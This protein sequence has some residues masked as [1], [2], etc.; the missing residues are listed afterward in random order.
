MSQQ[1]LMQL[2]GGV[3]Q[4]G[5]LSSLLGSMNRT[6]GASGRT[7]TTTPS[8]GANRTIASTTSVTTSNSSLPA[9]ARDPR[10]PSAATT[11]TP[12]TDS[13]RVLLSELQSYL[14]GMSNT[15]KN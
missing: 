5:G 2:F 4:M 15:G 12:A 1:Q 8:S 11:G 13:S 14:A 3:G 9:N 10:K 7:A 6:G